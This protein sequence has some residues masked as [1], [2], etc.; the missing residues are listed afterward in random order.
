LFKNLMEEN[1]KIYGL[2]ILYIT[3]SNGE[4]YDTFFG[5]DPLQKFISNGVIIQ[6]QVKGTS[7]W[8]GQGDLISKFSGLVFRDKVYF[9][10]SQQHWNNIKISSATS[11]TVLQGTISVNANSTIV[12]GANTKFE[13]NLQKTDSVVILN[14][15]YT[16]NTISSNTTLTVTPSVISTNANTTI[17]KVN[18]I[19]PPRP[20]EGDLI[21]FPIVKKLF[22][23][24]FVDHEAE[25]FYPIGVPLLYGLT[26]E[27]FDYSSEVINTGNT[28]VD[29][30]E[31]LF[32]QNE[33]TSNTYVL[34]DHNTTAQNQEITNYSNSIIV[35]SKK[36]PRL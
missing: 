33:L 27:L 15:V 19:L 5:E 8:G 21:W 12:T 22:S 17:T 24:L 25:S 14:S 16:V 7:N 34:E 6:S 3:R 35:S 20:L 23:I 13:T 28:D 11:N 31:D 1:I 10:I 36:D 2:P 4:G 18:R 32:T 29:I 9:D 30:I 26:C